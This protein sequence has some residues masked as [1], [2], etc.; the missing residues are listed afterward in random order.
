MAKRPPRQA[1]KAQTVAGRGKSLTPLWIVL[2]V[3]LLLAI[4]LP[5]MLIVGV[6]MLPT[7]VAF[8]ID[9]AQKK[10]ATFCV[11]GMNF[12]GVFPSLL[13]LWTGSHTIDSATDIITDVYALAAMYGASGFGWLLFIAIPPVVAAFLTVMAQHRIA[14]LR[15]SQ[16]QIIDEW[17]DDVANTPAKG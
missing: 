6:G 7:A 11:G 13:D 15:T 3:V 16:K 10:N 17:G 2:A 1:P 5:S 9:R 12:S 8:I 14:Q 4:S